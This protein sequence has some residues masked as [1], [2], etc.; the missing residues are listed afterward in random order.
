MGNNDSSR[1][2]MVILDFGVLA[3]NELRG[4]DKG[5]RGGGSRVRVDNQKGELIRPELPG[6]ALSIV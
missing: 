6:L 4:D 5:L 3:I 2:K 1:L